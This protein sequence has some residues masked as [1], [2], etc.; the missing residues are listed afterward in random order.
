MKN[1]II[2]KNNVKNNILK[3]AFEMI[4]GNAGKLRFP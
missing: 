4:K 1:L 2:N 3:E